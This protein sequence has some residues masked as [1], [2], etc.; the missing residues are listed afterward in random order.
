MN[1]TKHNAPS[2][3]PN[4]VK[5]SAR[6]GAALCALLVL[7]PMAVIV[8]AIGEFDAELWDFLLDYQLPILLKNTAILTVGVGLGV[9]WVGASCAWLLAMY[10]FPASKVLSWAMMLPLA[11]PAYVLAFTQLGFFEYSGAISTYLRQS[12][13]FENGLPDIRNAFGV[14]AVLTL[15][16]Y[17]YVYLLAKNAFSTMGNRALEVG[18]SLGLSPVRSFFK[19]A[20]PMARPWLAGGLMLALMEVLADF[21]AVSIFGFETFTTAI[22]E[23]WFGFFSLQTAKQLASLLI[24]FVFILVIFEQ[25]SRRRRRFEQA[26]RGTTTQPVRL[27]GIKAYLATAYCVLILMMAFVIPIIQLLAWAVQTWEGVLWGQ[28]WTQAWHSLVTA[29][30]GAAAVVAVALMLSLAGRY[31]NSLFTKFT[32]KISIMGYAIPGTVLAVGVFVPVAYLDNWL[33]DVLRLPEGTSI[34]RATLSVM[35]V[36][37]VIRFLALGVSSVAAGMERIKPS[38]VESANALGVSGLPVLTRIYL[39]LIKGSL[40]VALLMTFVD[41]MKEMPLTL[42][43]RPHHW[44]ML[45]VRI[46][47]FTMEGLF[48]KAALPALVI[49]LTGLVPVLLFSRWSEDEQHNTTMS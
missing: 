32:T 26:G 49:V 6:V 21:G 42:M 14:S 38:Y 7:I 47:S 44:D 9:L 22:Y 16:F 33:I 15:A 39:P 27:K 5:W 10:R 1:T 18:A 34:F 36:A 20:L 41:I 12:W 28:L 48:D 4:L 19:I 29:L 25:L 31:D 45:S 35:I 2:T 43:M 40:G 8:M 23:A 13:G 46:Y 37:Y 11:M 3:A 24:G 17:P 30:A